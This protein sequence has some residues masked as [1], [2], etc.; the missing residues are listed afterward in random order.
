MVFFSDDALTG[1]INEIKEK[2]TE[3]YLETNKIRLI[4]KSSLSDWLISAPIAYTDHSRNGRNPKPNDFIQVQAKTFIERLT[5]DHCMDKIIP[6]Y[7]RQS[8]SRSLSNSFD[9]DILLVVADTYKNVPQK[10]YTPDDYINFKL[11]QVKGFLI[12][13]KGG[14][15]QYPDLH[16]INLICSNAKQ[17]TLLMGMYIYTLFTTQL[18]ANKTG[19]LELAGGYNNIAGLC[20]YTKFGFVPDD[21]LHVDNCF[22]YKVNLPMSV[23]LNK[24]SVTVDDIIKV[25]IRMKPKLDIIDPNDTELCST[26]K[27]EADDYNQ[28]KQQQY[29]AH[30]FELKRTS[31]IYFP[32]NKKNPENKI[33]A[34]NVEN[35]I[36]ETKQE[37]LSLKAKSK[38]IDTEAN[39]M[40]DKGCG[41]LGC[42]ISGGKRKT[43][44]KKRGKRKKTRKRLKRTN[45]K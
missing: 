21:E 38:G 25:S 18:D 9:Y 32:V 45:K 34:D 17:G 8:T 7:A 10:Y 22:D 11:K 36:L 3:S 43:C 41:P 6:G 12:V 27:P 44:K 40:T 24:S 39:M 20:S 19:I 2:T 23:K 31:K 14:C 28:T 15:K 13:E 29:L 16:S 42:S 4:N 26:Y 37:I 30:L 35:L 1:F 33:R 5:D